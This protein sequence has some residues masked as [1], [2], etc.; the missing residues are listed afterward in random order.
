[1][2]LACGVQQGTCTCHDGLNCFCWLHFQLV[3]GANILEEDGVL[4]RVFTHLN[5]MTCSSACSMGEKI[6]QSILV[7]YSY[8]RFWTLLFLSKV[9][10]HPALGV[11]V[12]LWVDRPLDEWKIGV[13]KMI[14]LRVAANCL[15]HEVSWCHAMVRSAA[16]VPGCF[17]SIRHLCC[18]CGN[19]K[20]AKRF[21]GALCWSPVPSASPF[22]NGQHG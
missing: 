14:H 6:T 16:Y 2:R 1:M 22:S 7:Q 21:A 15:L 17:T 20:R 19:P 3:C 13:E 11:V 10:N 18:Y 8:K 12:V 9:S 5:T 4:V